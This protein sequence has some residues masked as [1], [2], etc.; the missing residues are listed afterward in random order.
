MDLCRAPQRR[1][2]NKIMPNTSPSVT[3]A[4]E[5]PQPVNVVAH[6]HVYQ[7]HSITCEGSNCLSGLVRAPAGLEQLHALVEFARGGDKRCRIFV[8]ELHARGQSSN[9][10]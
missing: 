6:R 1:A 5:Y 2:R 7:P 9:N 3:I 8:S 4:F 10:T